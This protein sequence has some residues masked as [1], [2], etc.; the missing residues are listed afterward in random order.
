MERNKYKYVW[1]ERERGLDEVGSS[2]DREKEVVKELNMHL[3][4]MMRGCGKLK[5]DL[6]VKCFAEVH[7]FKDEFM[8]KLYDEGV[9]VSDRDVIK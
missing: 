9:D 2:T 4:K 6:A 3:R 7:D 8:K 5:G 1:E